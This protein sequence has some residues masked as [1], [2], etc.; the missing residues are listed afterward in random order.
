MAT[1]TCALR[2]SLITMH[3]AA[4]HTHPVL[5][6]FVR[7]FVGSS[8]TGVDWLGGGAK[9]LG[10]TAPPLAAGATPLASGWYAP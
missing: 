5:K 6:T 4:L 3:I 1:Q 9:A 8:G 7:D 2:Q 10:A